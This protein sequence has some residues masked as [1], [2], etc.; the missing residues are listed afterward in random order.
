MQFPNCVKIDKM[1][2]K[3]TCCVCFSIH[4]NS[5]KKRLTWLKHSLSS[6]LI[7]MS[8]VNIA[9][10]EWG[11]ITVVN[12][13]SNQIT[14]HRD[15]RIHPMGCEEWDWCKSNTHHQPG[16]QF[17]DIEDLLQV[18]PNV[19]NVIL[20]MGMKNALNIHPN[21]I[22]TMQQKY[23]KVNLHTLTTM[24]AVALYQKLYKTHLVIALLHSTC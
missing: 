20:S 19:T 13:K 15:C 7:L 16:I 22:H 4:K 17:S 5:K 11:R 1:L 6:F 24:D 2:E 9:S 23:P 10:C 14:S 12:E 8:V 18:H 3:S 21:T